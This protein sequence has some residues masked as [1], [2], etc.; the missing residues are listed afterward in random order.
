M[1]DFLLE[2]GTEEIPDW[3][4]DGALADLRAKFQA[5]FGE[6]GGDAL[7][8][9]AT[10]RRLVLFAKGLLERAPDTQTV[11]QG[12]YLSAGPKAAE[13]FAK[14]QGTTVDQLAKMTRRERRTLRLPSARQ[15]TGCR[16]RRC[17]R[18]CRPSSQASIS[19][20]A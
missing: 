3:M 9:E 11:A 20:R 19:R 10:P 5:A 15:G 7:R 14:K 18:N 4:I 17:G 1:A 8:T 6:F 16:C 12:P 2:I 13:G